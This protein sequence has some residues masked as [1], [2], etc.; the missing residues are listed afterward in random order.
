MM[1]L[2]QLINSLVNTISSGAGIFFGFL[3]AW[4]LF[5]LQE[6]HK[7]ALAV[8]S[9]R[10][11]LLGELKWLESHLSII[12]IKCAIQSDIVPD[13]VKEMRWFL[14]EG[15][16]R[17]TLEELPPG[18]LEN[19]DKTLA[20]PDEEVAKLLRFFKHESQAIEMPVTITNSILAS[21][22]TAKLSAEEIK[23]LID[24]RWQVAMLTA[25]ARNMNENLRLTF[26]VSDEENHKIVKINH[27][28]CLHM[29][30]RRANYLLRYVR[31]ALGELEN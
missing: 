7:Q 21:P 3:S 18:T 28:K 19:R 16:A 17:N 30:G 31:A 5:I 24:V 6:R 15:F 20:L 10:Q 27:A 26:T 8:Q 14:K 13:G 22:T 29:Y 12:V 4:G 11:S 25:E 1:T 23:K 2:A 9:T